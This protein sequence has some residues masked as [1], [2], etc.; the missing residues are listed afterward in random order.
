MRKKIEQFEE[1]KEKRGKEKGNIL[2]RLSAPLPVEGIQR[3]RKEDTKKGYDTTGYGYQFCV[4]RFNEVCGEEW[5]YDYKILKEIKGQF[6]SGQ[7]YFEIVI[8]LEIWVKNRENIRKCVGGHLSTSYADALKGAI[9]NAFKKTASFW[10]VGREAYAGIIDE[11]N[12]PQKEGLE[13]IKTSQIK[14]PQ[15]NLLQETG[16][17]IMEMTNGDKGKASAILEEITTWTDKEGKIVGGKSSLKDISERQTPIV[18]GKVKKLYQEW[19]DT[20]SFNS[21]YPDL[22]TG[23]IPIPIPIPKE[24]VE[25]IMTVANIIIKHD[26]AFEEVFRMY[27]MS[28]YGKKGNSIEDLVSELVGE[29][30]DEVIKYLNGILS[31]NKEEVRNENKNS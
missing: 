29:Q 20:Q 16:N 8:E 9:T 27:L 19:K 18:Y 6:R 21:D 3:T 1:V 7:E 28:E 31:K 12:V 22:R 13:D 14:K 17:M 15:K 24:Q 30:G 11:D 2:Q 4:D 25:K 26:E 10:G 23:D 5:G